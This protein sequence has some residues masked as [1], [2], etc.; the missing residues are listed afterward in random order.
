L[1]RD[2]S[3]H[4]RQGPGGAGRRAIQIAMRTAPVNFPLR[5]SRGDRASKAAKT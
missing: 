4:S 2:R 5:Y 1:G 3:A